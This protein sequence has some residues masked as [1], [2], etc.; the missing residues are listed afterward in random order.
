[1]IDGANAMSVPKL[2]STDA[3]ILVDV[4]NDFCPGGSLAV[5]GGDEVVPVLNGWIA[6]AEKAG[7][8]V[9]A[10]RDWHPSGH[11]SF[12][13]SGGPWPA[14]CIQMT[15]GAEFH[16]QLQ[17]PKDAPIVSKGAE[18]ERDNYSAFAGTG[19]GDQLRRRGVR[20]VFVGGLAQD[21]CVRATV[22]DALQEGF[23]VHLLLNATRPVDV[24]GGQRAVEEMRAAGCIVEQGGPNA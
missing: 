14:H 22:L 6:A 18:R 24:A 15:R 10:S 7:A 9:A 4:Q 11:V 1:V 16:P 23:E 13:E 17:V 5:S 21:Y 2:R 3:L 19:L 12:R 8:V 20:R